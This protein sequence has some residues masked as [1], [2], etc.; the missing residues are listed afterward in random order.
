[1]AAGLVEIVRLAVDR[2]KEGTE[3]F[4][5]V[6]FNQ[7]GPF[8]NTV[9]AWVIQFS[10]KIV[11]GNSKGIQFLVELSNRGQ[12]DVAFQPY[13]GNLTI[14]KEIKVYP[15]GSYDLGFAECGDAVRDLV[16]PVLNRCVAEALGV[17]GS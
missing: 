13:H 4:L 11:P 16:E 2:V 12:I 17:D 14:F 7:T 10:N 9:A 1:M 6:Q 5:N 8:G 3:K 15:L